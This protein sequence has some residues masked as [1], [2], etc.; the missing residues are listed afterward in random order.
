M[1][2]SDNGCITDGSAL[3]KWSMDYINA[4]DGQKDPRSPMQLQRMCREAGLINVE[5]R[6]IPLPLCDWGKGETARSIRSA[7]PTS[8]WL[9]PK[10]QRSVS[11]RLGKPTLNR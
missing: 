11:R 7:H 1:V 2:Q 4:L 9:I 5:G 10:R 3:R 8:R 6:M